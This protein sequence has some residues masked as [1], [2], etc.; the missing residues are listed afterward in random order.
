MA[1]TTMNKKC[2]LGP[3]PC[4]SPSLVTPSTNGFGRVT[5][6]SLAS[7]LSTVPIGVSG[8]PDAA[9]E[10]VRRVVFFCDNLGVFVAY[11]V[12]GRDL[13]SDFMASG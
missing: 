5:G 11:K 13:P 6:S 7:L 4:V 10:L 9:W 2:S 8:L 3:V 12:I 1:I